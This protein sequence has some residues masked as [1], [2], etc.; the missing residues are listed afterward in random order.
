MP[1]RSPS[2]ASSTRAAS[3]DLRREHEH[4][5][6]GQR[7]AERG[8]LPLPRQILGGR[9]AQGL[10]RA[11]AP[12]SASGGSTSTPRGGRVSQSEWGCPC[13]ARSSA[14]AQRRVST[15]LPPK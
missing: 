1:S 6:R 9:P 7:E 14:S 13:H 5:E 15:A 4:A 8:G 12:P 2:A 3:L 11:A 10:D